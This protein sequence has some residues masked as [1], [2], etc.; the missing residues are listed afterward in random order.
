VTTATTNDVPQV[1]DLFSPRSWPE[2][3][4][5]TD[6][7]ISALAL[8]VLF[9]VGAWLTGRALRLAIHRYLD[10]AQHAGG[11]ATGIRFLGQLGNVAV[12]IFAF[13]IYSHLIPSLQ[14][15]GTAW[16]TSM[17]VVSVVVGLAAQSTLGNLI[18]GIS[19]VLYRPF[20][21]GD[22]LQI[23]GPKGAEIGTVESIN[24]GTTVLL[25]ADD[26]RLVIP[27]N[28]MATTICINLSATRKGAPCTVMVTLPASADVGSAR[29]ILTEAAKGHTGTV[30]VDSCNITAISAA[31]TELTL[32]AWCANAG[33]ATQLK[34]DLLESVKKQFD[35]GGIKIV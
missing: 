10:K 13:M 24:L 16:L 30:A 21:V 22:Q 9:L 35:A 1:H 27:N 34:S 8:G 5:N 33:E 12:Y 26:R 15:L 11:D 7:D 29:K 14:H 4:F 19:L 18:S 3:V 25:T 2:D 31:G 17:G 6:T 20:K 28:T 23:T 32:N